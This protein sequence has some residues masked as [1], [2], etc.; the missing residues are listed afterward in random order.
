MRLRVVIATAAVLALVGCTPGPSTE[1]LH[2]SRPPTSDVWASGD[3]ITNS[4]HAWPNN[5]GDP[6]FNISIGYEGFVTT[7]VRPETIGQRIDH[8]VA[9]FGPPDRIVIMGGR[10][11]EQASV[12]LAA[13]IAE[14][15]R[16]DLRLRAQG[17]DVRWVTPPGRVG[18]PTPLTDGIG[19]HLRAA[20]PSRTIDCGPLLGSPTGNPAL[21]E[22]D[23]IHP[24]AAGH[25]VLTDCVAGEFGL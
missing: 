21:F 20:Y 19:A 4:V 18:F 11:D 25:L 16:L 22:N 9:A 1:L 17:I 2:S 3:S 10:N 14:I 15:D 8:F 23:G 24:N 12:P 6:V 5:V 13:V 7:R